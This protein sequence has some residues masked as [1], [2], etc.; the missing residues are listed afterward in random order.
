MPIRVA[1]K[2]PFQYS[3]SLWRKKQRDKSITNY[4]NLNLQITCIDWQLEIK[5]N[6]ASDP[7]SLDVALQRNRS[8]DGDPPL[9]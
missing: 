4:N 5:F 7:E 1:F 3:R 8:T 9:S 2:A 6:P